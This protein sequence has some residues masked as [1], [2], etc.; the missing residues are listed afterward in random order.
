MISNKDVIWTFEK[1]RKLWK[2]HK[3]EKGKNSPNGNSNINVVT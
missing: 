3:E 2:Q 1:K